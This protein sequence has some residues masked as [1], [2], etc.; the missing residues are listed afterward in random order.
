MKSSV[1]AAVVTLI[2]AGA[3]TPALAQTADL[4]PLI[5]NSP[6]DVA[7][8]QQ[9]APY[10]HQISTTDFLVIDDSGAD[11]SIECTIGSIDNS[12]K[13]VTNVF[14]AGLNDYGT[15]WEVPDGRHTVL[16]TATDAG[17]QTATATHVV[18]VDIQ[19]ALFPS[20]A[21]ETRMKKIARIYM[22]GVIDQD[23]Y[24]LIV[25]Y[26]HRAGLI[27][28][29]IVTDGNGGFG[30][31]ISP[32]SDTAQRCTYGHWQHDGYYSNELSNWYHGGDAG[33]V[34][35][36]QCLENLANTGLFDRLNLGF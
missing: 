6:S 9:T 35:Y 25:K 31:S 28:F 3:A 12:T 17:G 33:N 5:A 34:H 30:S 24:H 2:A 16:C 1:I 7:I 14:H 23:T 19:G 22:N 20:D 8:A 13:A 4:P 18:D 21:A 29:D 32:Q 11:V 15:V 10:L 26:Y 27:S 36:K